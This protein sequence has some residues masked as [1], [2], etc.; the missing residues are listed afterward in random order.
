MGLT[1]GYMDLAF[2]VVT[3]VYFLKHMVIIEQVTYLYT[4]SSDYL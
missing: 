4:N 2:S 3:N 1:K